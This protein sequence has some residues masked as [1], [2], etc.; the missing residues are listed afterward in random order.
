MVR[1]CHNCGN[2]IPE[3]E[4]YCSKCGQRAIDLDPSQIKK[5]FDENVK[6]NFN[7]SYSQNNGSKTKGGSNNQKRSNKGKNKKKR[8][9][10]AK[11]IFVTLIILILLFGIA[12]IK[13]SPHEKNYVDSY[14]AATVNQSAH[15]TINIEDGV[16]LYGLG[17]SKLIDS[18]YSV[19]DKYDNF[20]VSGYENYEVI[21]N[22]GDW[23]YISIYKVDFKNLAKDTSCY[24]YV[25][26]DGNDYICFN[27]K[28]KSYAYFINIPD[29][30]DNST[31]QTFE[32]LESIFYY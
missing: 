17:S 28:G 19:I 25:D 32:F 2:E 1:Y 21:L 4:K 24:P 23:Y 30:S 7:S 15:F 26:E 6:T 29:S 14:G 10:N 13:Y 20:T 11:I 16:Y 3:N 22:T 9:S 8:F 18:D 12:V 27:P 31:Y 5:D